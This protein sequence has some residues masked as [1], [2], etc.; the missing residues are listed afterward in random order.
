MQYQ[1]HDSDG[2]SVIRLGMR[3]PS[4]GRTAKESGILMDTIHLI[5]ESG[6]EQGRMIRVPSAGARMGRA[7]TNDLVIQDPSISRF[8]CRFFFR[9]GRDLC[10]A[11]LASTNETLVND[12]PVTESQLV[13]GDRILIGETI[14][15]VACDTLAGSAD[16]SPAG[17]TA[18]PPPAPAA[19]A[20]A[21][22]AG[23]DATVPIPL[24]RRVPAAQ[25][26]DLGLGETP[27]RAVRGDAG[28]PAVPRRLPRAAV[29][30]AV[31]ATGILAVAGASYVLLKDR[32]R[33]AAA[34]PA[35][36][37]EFRYEKIEATASNIFWYELTLHSGRLRARLKDVTDRRMA[38]EERELAREQLDELRRIASDPQVMSLNREYEGVSSEAYFSKRIAVILGGREQDVRVLNRPDPP[39]FQRLSEQLETFAQNELGLVSIAL[40]R[41]TLLENARVTFLNARKLYDEREVRREN[42]ARAL[43]EFRKLDILAQTLEPKPE[44]YEDAV[45]M[46][47]EAQRMFDDRCRDVMFQADQAIR[48][49][50]WESAN[51]HLLVLQDMI[52]DR[53][54]ERAREVQKKLVDVQRRIR[55]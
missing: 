28:E 24:V 52:D 49:R 18:P 17:A 53:S 36:I 22:P 23:M 19:D 16:A 54:D 26:I 48:L 29:R 27:P 41:E 14:M 51:R 33:P 37:F 6:P 30:V 4:G 12:R 38:D 11:D 35:N 20:T 50:D 10:I 15:R 1:I 34:D 55:R 47:A 32:P 21:A 5:V 3:F 2:R 25:T 7:S 44:Y 9:N 39:A 46:A 43:R 13:K 8:Q 45:A 42:L 40:P 31:M